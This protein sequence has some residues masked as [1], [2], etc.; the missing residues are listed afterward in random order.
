MRFA[1]LWRLDGKVDRKTYALVGLIGF[2]IKRVLDLLTASHFLHRD[3]SFFNYWL[4]LGRGARLSRLSESEV[5]FLATMLLVAMPFI[6]IGLAMTV[7]RLRDAGQPV[8]LV[9][10]FFVPVLNVLFFL[11]LCLL[12]PR[13]RPQIKE[14]A[15]WPECASSR[16]NHPAQR[17]RQRRSLDCPHNRDRAVLPAAGNENNRIV[18]LE[19]FRCAAILPRIVFGAAL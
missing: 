17:T 15:P 7:R 13:E 5:K 3:V 16:W 18:W 14:A 4:P 1:D 8:W 2:A 19:S 11:A 10:L 6:W 9:V 12:P